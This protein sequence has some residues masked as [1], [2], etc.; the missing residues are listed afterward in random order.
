MD[1]IQ[2][3]LPF[4][5]LFNNSIY[6]YNENIAVHKKFEKEYKGYWIH[7]HVTNYQL[8]CVNFYRYLFT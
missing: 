1:Y 6:R 7:R 2:Y 8:F 5:E 4:T 3:Y